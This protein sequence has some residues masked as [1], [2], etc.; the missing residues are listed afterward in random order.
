MIVCSCNFIRE[1]Q[2]REAARGGALDVVEVYEAL[3]CVP[4]C[5]QCLPFAEQI[6]ED[7]VCA[8]A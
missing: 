7:E 2:I 8:A 4:N 3:G 5:C 1:Q 6:I